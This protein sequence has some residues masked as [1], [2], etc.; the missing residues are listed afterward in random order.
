GNLSSN[1][2]SMWNSAPSTLGQDKDAVVKEGQHIVKAVTDLAHQPG[3]VGV[4]AAGAGAALAGA[5][6]VIAGLRH[7]FHRNKH[8]AHDHHGNGD[9]MTFSGGGASIS[10]TSRGTVNTGALPQQAEQLSGQQR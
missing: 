4:I 6:L 7:A 8:H 3:G 2:Q 10:G 5:G 9:E 1:I